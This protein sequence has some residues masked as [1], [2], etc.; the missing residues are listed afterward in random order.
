MPQGGPIATVGTHTTE[1][2]GLES[3]FHRILHTGNAHTDV[4]GWL[5]IDKLSLF[6]EGAWVM[7]VHRSFVPPG[8]TTIFAVLTFFSSL[9]INDTQPVV[10]QATFNGIV[11]NPNTD[12]PPTEWSGAYSWRTANLTPRTID[13]PNDTPTIISPPKNLYVMPSSLIRFS[14]CRWQAVDG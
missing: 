1:L 11:D 9:L 13:P 4:H 8:G 2:P 14:L 3:F 10:G 7:Q 12:D 5:H 6:G